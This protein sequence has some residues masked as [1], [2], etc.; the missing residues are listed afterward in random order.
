M[1]VEITKEDEEKLSRL[2]TAGQFGNVN[3]AV[4]EAINYLEQKILS[5]V[6]RAPIWPEGL[7][8]EV[9]RGESAQDE[10]KFLDGN[11]LKVEPTLK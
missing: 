5:P 7:L 9:Y 6:E 4:H 2:I 11:S 8:R 3:A 1:T 10:L